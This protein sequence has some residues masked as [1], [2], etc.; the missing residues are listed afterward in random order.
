[1][2]CMSHAYGRTL[3]YVSLLLRQHDQAL[4][5]SMINLKTTLSPF[6]QMEQAP[7]FSAKN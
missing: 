5:A 2:A 3:S 1:M 7:K 6:T 4:V